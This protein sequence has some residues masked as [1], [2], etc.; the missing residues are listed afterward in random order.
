MSPTG[1]GRPSPTG[2]ETQHD[3]DL[4]TNR[5]SNPA[6]DATRGLG[7]DQGPDATGQDTLKTGPGK[8]AL[9]KLSQIIAVR[10][11]I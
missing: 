4:D 9:A 6:S 3:Q 7:I 10:I 11:D 1:P 2:T 8:E 5:P